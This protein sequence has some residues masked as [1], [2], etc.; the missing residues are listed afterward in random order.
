MNRLI[1][2]FSNKALLI[3]QDVTST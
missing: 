2:R 1:V 3:Y